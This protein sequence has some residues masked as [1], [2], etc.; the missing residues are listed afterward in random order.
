MKRFVQMVLFVM[1]L[2]A[3]GLAREP[4]GVTDT[5]RSPHARLKSIGIGDV[6][7]TRGFWADRF[8]L[9]RKVTIPTMWDAMQ[10]PGNG[11]YFGNMRI[12]AGL[13]EGEYRGTVYG[14]GDIYKWV[15]AA[16]HVYHLS[17]DAS[18]DRLM[19]D[20]IR[21]IA[22][23]QTPEG[24]I[25][26]QTQVGKH[27]RWEVNRNHE[28]YS[29][30]HLITAGCIHYRATG[31]RTLLDIAVKT[32][33]YLYRTFQPRPPEL[34]H[35]AYNPSQI[36]ALVELYRTTRDER[37]LEL[38]GI[39][40]DMRGAAPGGVDH[41]QDRVPLREETEAVGHAVLGTYL[42]SGAA[43]VYAETGERGL[44]EALARLWVDVT[45]R[46]MAVTGGNAVLFQGLTTRHELTHEAFGAAYE[47]PNR[48][49]KHETCA[50]IGNAM[51][52]WRMLAATGEARYADVIE[53]VSYNILLAAM[54]ANGKEY[55]YAN[56][57]RRFAADLPLTSG[58][59][60]TRW[61]N[62][63]V[64]GAP[65]GFCCPP[66]IARTIAG[67]HELAYSTSA[68]GLWVNLYGANVFDNGALRLKQETDYPW[69]GRIS[70]TVERSAQPEW[71]LLL[72][73][74]GWAEGATLR[75]N[76]KPRPE[77]R[78]GA[79]VAVRRRWS[80]GD[81]VELLLPMT[82]RL[83]ES[84]PLVEETRNHAA[85]MRGP[86]VY[87]LESPDLPADVRF[88]EVAVPAGIRFEARHEAGL[89]GGLTVLEGAAE[90]LARA[91]W[92]GPLYRP[93]A[94]PAAVG[95]RLRLIPYYA[96]ANRGVS[97]MTV[98]LPLLR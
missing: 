34:A 61:A 93:L 1:V 36:M 32:A 59:S 40:V 27:K 64:A 85:V 56:P 92:S 28:L 49:A 5:S 51:W 50:A 68:E 87:C 47:L 95:F 83:V 17:G 23:A 13:A 33:D 39:F 82:P 94:A 67:L 18:L 19:D 41:N 73:V 70:I 76:G 78:P 12:A 74:P 81:K 45:T 46:K 57:L 84:H 21:V 53:L 37:Y 48:D 29:M 97:Y 42:W 20:A 66:N 52:A 44:W 4:A 60:P 72:R 62:N 63:T 30:G 58:A 43:D 26:T 90:R 6:R 7:W 16:A 8:E 79:Y 55:F 24:Y 96:W 15:E 31:K 2:P 22:K 14:D 11:A 3:L 80:A 89:L 65:G 10:V 54:G 35:F 77:A 25:A 71:S 9:V 86:L 91:G 69:D 88:T 98:W 75:V 38:A